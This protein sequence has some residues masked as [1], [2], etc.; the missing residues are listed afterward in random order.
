[1]LF[2][3]AQLTAA[4]PQYEVGAELGRGGFGLVIEGRHRRLGRPVAI[5]ILTISGP[6]VERRFLA[7][8]QVM[9]VFDHPH[10][11]RVHDYAESDGL[12]L[13]VME[14]LP[15]GTL[16][17]RIAEGLR[18]ETAI[19]IGLAISDAL[20]AAHERGI[21]HRDIKPDNVLF[22]A[23]GAVKVTDFGIAKLF[24]GSTITT[25]TLVGT[26]AYAA[27]EQILGQRIGPQTDVYAVGGL[28]YHMLAG[29]TPFSLAL[30]FSAMLH[31]H[32]N[33]RPELPAGM[34]PRIAEVVGQAL[35]KESADRPAS[36]KEFALAL[37]DA[38][39]AEFGPGWSARAEI[40]L[41]V[42]DDIR[43]AVTLTGGAGQARLAA[44]AVRPGSPGITPSPARRPR[45]GDTPV[46]LQTP[47]PGHLAI[48]GYAEPP[49]NPSYG[50]GVPPAAATTPGWGFTPN[51][52]GHG[53]RPPA[54]PT[55]FLEDPS[56]GLP[57]SVATPDPRTPLPNRDVGTSY[58]HGAPPETTGS[59]PVVPRSRS[60]RHAA[61]PGA[62]SGA[63]G[64][65]RPES[66]ADPFAVSGGARHA[67]QDHPAPAGRAARRHRQPEPPEA[68]AQGV[69]VRGV[70]A[71]EA[72]A[73]EEG[74]SRR[75]LIV[76][77][78]V[79]ALIAVISVAIGAAIGYTTR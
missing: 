62:D 49:V 20:H 77:V 8:A 59:V 21:V 6:D 14:H 30:P 3:R 17:S 67:S 28:I 40:P 16:T 47:P 33:T 29:R 64:S 52:F 51:S 42:D 79:V 5:K 7:E 36:A 55:S 32:L 78:A 37:A 18:P 66:P 27:P 50:H 19:A 25:G 76:L 10:V 41:R 70:G 73:E 35:E 2:D 44:A 69:G 54:T 24:E 12:C 38:A 23:D 53:V 4:L 68:G 43:A 63:A 26:P 61:E 74:I 22:A 65:W 75:M 60:G 48:P 9:A 56:S 72:G 1:M 39:A 15:G 34:P 13:I 11:V 46:Q 57:P 31:H 71:T 58:G 45:S